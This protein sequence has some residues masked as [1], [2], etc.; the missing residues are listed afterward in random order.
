M[1]VR[2]WGAALVSGLMV[3]GGAVLAGP[4]AARARCEGPQ[5]SWQ[6]G[7]GALTA[8]FVPSSPRHTFNEFIA[9]TT[10]RFT[11]AQVAALR[12]SGSSAF[13]VDAQAYG[14]VPRSGLKGWSSNLP[15]A[16]IDTEF[17]DSG[18]R[19]LTVGSRSAGK[20]KANTEYYTRVRLR[21]IGTSAD[22]ARLQLTFQRG[23]WASKRSPKEQT[24]CLAHGGRDPA[25]CVFADQSLPM[26]GVTGGPA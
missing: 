13:E 10:F 23:H 18:P 8:E 24:S 6:P 26:S 17:S 3:T 9:V 5:P 4:A 16:Y 15:D 7:G 19:V 12:C 1:R 2:R 25:W 14:G 22:P 21:E 11:E 20:I